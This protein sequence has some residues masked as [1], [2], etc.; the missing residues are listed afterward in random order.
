MAADLKN[1]SD[2]LK[3]AAENSVAVADAIGTV[4]V[5]EDF[6]KADSETADLPQEK[7]VP[8]ISI[9]NPVAK[10]LLVRVV[11]Q[12]RVGNVQVK[13]EQAADLKAYEKK[14]Y[15]TAVKAPDKS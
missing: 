11:L 6:E 2:V 4:R 7:I 12:D 14:N 1:L 5:V 8:V 13:A 15:F 3:A 9:D 10:A